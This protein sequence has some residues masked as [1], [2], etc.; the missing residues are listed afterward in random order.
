MKKRASKDLTKKTIPQLIRCLDPIFSKYIRL[1]NSVDEY[2]RCFTC[3]KVMHWKEAH[4]GHFQPRTKSPTRF[5]ESNNYPQCSYCNTFNEGETT[6]YERRLIDLLGKDAVEDLIRESRQ[7][8][9]W[10][11]GYLIEKI[12]FYRT[13]LKRYS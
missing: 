10:D 3:D 13:E 9:K 1:S 6:E 5:S 12:E 8:W 7:S 4:C 11:R 2:C